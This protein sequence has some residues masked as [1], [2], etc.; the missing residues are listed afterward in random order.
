MKYSKISKVLLVLILGVFMLTGCPHPNNRV[1]IKVASLPDNHPE[2]DPI[3]FAGSLNNW[4]ANSEKWKL[5][6]DEN[7]NYSIDLNFDEKEDIDKII[8]FKFTRGGWDKEELDPE[9]YT[10]SNRQFTYK[11]HSDEIRVSIGK[12]KDLEG[13]S[14]GKKP[15][16]LGDIRIHSMTIP[17]IE[18]RERKIRVYLPPNYENNDKRY[19]V[20]YMHD[21]Q[22]LFDEAS[23][24][25]GMEWKVDE[26]LE[27]FYK[28]GKTDGV[29]VVGIDSIPDKKL[30]YEEY[31]SFNWSHP[32][33]GPIEAKGEAYGK[34]IIET[35]KPFIDNKYRTYADRENTAIAGS[36][37]GGY[38]SIYI[39]MKYQDH[40][41][42]VAS[43]STVALDNPMVGYK[44]RELVEASDPTY[45]IEVYL[46]I[47]D[48]ETL[49]YATEPEILIQSNRK[50][51]KSFQ[52]AGFENITC[53]TIKDGIHNE[54]SWAD[55]FG[56]IFSILFKSTH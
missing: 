53:K 55:R 35:L 7:G 32:D 54:N 2:G 42:K 16:A 48:Q 25:F 13:G 51:C 6:L 8:Q 52:K 31:T 17:Q 44:L 33:V 30:R 15:T 26:T 50:M 47:G 37:M 29:I 40:F 28:A 49:S 34:F 45:D 38:I 24:S 9:G 3:F 39:A 1:T 46:D 23:A 56:D 20:L 4:K 43:V 36:S 5:T 11:G 14:K 27:D 12:W 18:D 10:L 19:P 41:S 22:N 21:G